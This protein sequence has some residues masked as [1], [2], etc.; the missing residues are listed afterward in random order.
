MI[1]LLLTMFERIGTV[2]AIA[3][4]L[5]HLD[6]VDTFSDQKG[7]KPYSQAYQKMITI[8]SITD[9]RHTFAYYVPL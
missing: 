6:I 2:V 1:K 4:V 3:F 5:A 9:V 8:H 7:L